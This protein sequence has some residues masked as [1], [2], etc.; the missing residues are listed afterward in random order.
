MPIFTEKLEHIWVLTPNYPFKV[1]CRNCSIVQM[2]SQTFNIT[3]IL[4]IVTRWFLIVIL[5]SDW[6]FFLS[7]LLYLWSFRPSVDRVSSTHMG[8]GSS[9]KAIPN[10]LNL[11]FLQQTWYVDQVLWGSILRGPLTRLLMW[12]ISWITCCEW[13]HK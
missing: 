5:Q 10:M 12:F 7:C 6:L 1:N 4:S 13:L 9:I 3:S 8:G 11:M 2:L